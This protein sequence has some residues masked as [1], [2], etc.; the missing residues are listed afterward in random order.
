MAPDAEVVLKKR[1]LKALAAH[2]KMAL[3]CKAKALVPRPTYKNKRPTVEFYDSPGASA[4]YDL[5]HA[6][7][8]EEDEETAAPAAAPAP[9]VVARKKTAPEKKAPVALPGKPKPKSSASAPSDDVAELS[10]T[11]LQLQRELQEL[12]AARDK[13]QLEEVVGEESRKLAP[14]YASYRRP[15][16]SDAQV[17]MTAMQSIASSFQ[18][19]AAQHTERLLTVDQRLARIE[20]ALSI[21]V[22]TNQ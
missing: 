17:F 14:V 20:A 15:P 12:R 19:T 22:M 1:S 2:Y 8:N 5:C 7:P 16:S 13:V 21:Q 4:V 6:A 3:T 18:A 10:A 11:K 9:A